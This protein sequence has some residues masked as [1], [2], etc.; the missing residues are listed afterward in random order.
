MTAVNL[1]RGALSPATADISCHSRSAASR[2]ASCWM[3]ALLGRPKLADSLSLDPPIDFVSAAGGF[4]LAAHRADTI[5]DV[6]A[7]LCEALQTDRSTLIDVEVERN[8][9]PV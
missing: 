4:G 5:E 1:P 9:Q 2:R 6:R 7:L 3:H 8:W